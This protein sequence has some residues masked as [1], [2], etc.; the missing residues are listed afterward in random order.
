MTHKAHHPAG[1]YTPFHH[2][3]TY[4]DVVETINEILG[5]KLSALVEQHIQCAIAAADAPQ[6][7]DHPAIK[8]LTKAEDDLHEAAHA[9]LKGQ[10]SIERF[11]A[12]IEYYAYRAL[13]NSHSSRHVPQK[14]IDAI[15]FHELP[16]QI[17]QAA[18]DAMRRD[19]K[20]VQSEF[21]DQFENLFMTQGIS[22][23]WHQSANDG[24]A[25][26]GGS[27]PAVKAWYT[28]AQ[29][30]IGVGD[31]NTAASAS[32]YDLQAATNRLWVAMDEATQHFQP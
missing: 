10:W 22:T 20:S 6:E 15:K 11:D 13:H 5:E 19:K 3:L 7:P 29:A 12:P 16:A 28:N 8:A 4:Q 30:V 1:V 2:E 25:N 9:R 14:E 32:Q 26:S 27:V 17:R 18:D 21:A 24:A 31:S 23:L